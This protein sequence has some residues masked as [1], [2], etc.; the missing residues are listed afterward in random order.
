MN[1]VKYVRDNIGHHHIVKTHQEWMKIDN[2]KVN[3]A[4]YIPCRNDWKEKKMNLVD[5][6][7]KVLAFFFTFGASVEIQLRNESKTNLN[8]LLVSLSNSQDNS[9]NF[10]LDSKVGE[11]ETYYSCQQVV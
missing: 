8:L 10:F 3:V 6:I 2:V 7:L 1:L 9:Q 5:L 11:K 4:A